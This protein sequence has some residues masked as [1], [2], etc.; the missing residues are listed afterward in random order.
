LFIGW[1]RFDHPRVN[2]SWAILNTMRRPEPDDTR[3]TT[4]DDS[5]RTRGGDG[6]DDE[7]D[8][9]P[10][11][12]GGPRNGLGLW[13]PL[14]II[15]IVLVAAAFVGRFVMTPKG[16][17]Q[18]D[19]TPNPT[20]TAALPPVPPPPTATP[21]MSPL[22]TPPPRPADALADWAAK[23]SLATGIPSV[24]V[25]A[26]G[27]AQLLLQQE[28]P[29]CHLGWTT[30]AAIGEIESDHG[31]A[32]GAVLQPNG[33]SVPPIEGP[34]LDGKDGRPLVTD[35]DAGAYDG[36]S[37]YDHMMGPL[38]LLPAVWAVY[39]TDADN[40]G[41]LDPYGIDD[42]SAALAKLLCSGPGDM[43]T[44]SGWKAAVARY[45]AGDQYATQVFAAAD[46]YGQRS[47]SVG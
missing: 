33:R 39:R 41:I 4:A 9:A 6:F 15:A 43:N 47:S 44:L 10:L 27:Y 1:F 28:Q 11:A 8:L 34:A 20:V 5:A 24:A 40:D 30:L 2:P 23:V 19:V 21:S 36:D 17:T 13:L 35:T 31:R 22:P 16:S 14:V 7:N 46:S 32:G 29:A 25:E 38:H 3:Q 12:H 37:T 18:S 42:A 26:Y 45:H